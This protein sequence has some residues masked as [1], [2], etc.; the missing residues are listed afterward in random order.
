MLKGIGARLGGIR[1]AMGSASR[2]DPGLERRAEIGTPDADTTDQAKENKV[3]DS[4]H[5]WCHQGHSATRRYS[6]Y[7]RD[8]R[9]A[10]VH[11]TTQIRHPLAS[12]RCSNHGCFPSDDCGIG[13]TF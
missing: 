5:Q 12:S 11:A 13:E 9:S 10:I 3:P 6:R 2:Q 4:P 1:S 7:L 8:C